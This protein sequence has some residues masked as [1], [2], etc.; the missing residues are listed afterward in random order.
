VLASSVSAVT[1]TNPTITA[2]LQSCVNPFAIQTPL[3]TAISTSATSVLIADTVTVPANGE[4]IY[5]FEKGNP[6]TGKDEENFRGEWM[7]VTSSSTSG[8]KHTLTVV[9]AVAGTSA[10]AFTPLARVAYSNAWASVPSG[11]SSGTTT[12]TTGAVTATAGAVVALNTV[13]L[14]L[15]AD[16]EIAGTFFR[17]L[18]VAGGTTPSVTLAGT[19]SLGSL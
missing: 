3:D 9:R 14:N 10:V 13:A 8:G 11:L 7:R 12:I 1:G 5:V 2:T 6:T 18:Y 4:F 17:M 16:K 19:L 15:P